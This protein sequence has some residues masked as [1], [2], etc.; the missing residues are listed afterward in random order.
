MK[1]ENPYLKNSWMRELG[2]ESGVMMFDWFQ[3]MAQSRV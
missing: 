2:S 1:L 3:V